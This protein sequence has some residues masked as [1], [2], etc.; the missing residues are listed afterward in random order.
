MPLQNTVCLHPELEKNI[1]SWIQNRPTAAL[2]LYGAPGVGKTTLAYRIYMS[3][4]LKVIEFNASHFR[5]GT[6]FR[7]TILPLLCQG[8]V[9]EL[10]SKGKRGGLGVLLDEI[11]GLSPGEKG[12]LSELVTYLRAWDPKSPGT[13]LILISNTLENRSLLQISKLC[14][15]YEVGPAPRKQV[16]EWLGPETAIPMTWERG[17]DLSGDLRAL[18]RFAAGLEGEHEINEYPDGV[19]SIAWWCLWNPW[20][21]W[22]DLDIENNEG[23]LAGLVSTENLPERLEASALDKNL[24]EDYLHIFQTLAE[25]DR[26]DYWAFFYQCWNLLPF[27]HS[28][29]L[30]NLGLHLTKE[31]PLK[32]DAVIPEVNKLRYT[33]VLTR[34]SGMFNAW[35]LLCELSDTYQF[36]IRLSPMACE[37]EL[38]TA[39]ALKADRK[40]RLQ[41]LRIT[42]Q[43]L[44]V[45]RSLG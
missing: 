2:L 15:T 25:S 11:D 21:I 18:Q 12:G 24:W 10:I 43:A 34:Q 29:K 40:R 30:K 44:T 23:N 33:S 14:T 32:E 6:S 26:A 16:E 28:L 13:P 1:Q 9:L 38:L 19:L 17:S 45:L 4:S 35:K 27:S 20:S 22:V 8:G 3:N 31:Y 41:N 5:S 42:T 7:K 36:P 39:T 37:L